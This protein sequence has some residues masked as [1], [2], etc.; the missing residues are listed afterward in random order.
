MTGLMD[1]SM[2]EFIAVEQ[3]RRRVA[4]RHAIFTGRCLRTESFPSRT[5]IALIPGRGQALIHS[6][7]M[8]RKGQTRLTSYKFGV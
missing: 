6:E 7:P 8:T 4:I 2:E 3:M 1:Q 5:S